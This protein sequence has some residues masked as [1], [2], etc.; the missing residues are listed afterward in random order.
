MIR[1]FDITSLERSCRDYILS[2][3]FRREE[4]ILTIIDSFS[5]FKMPNRCKKAKT[6]EV[7]TPLWIFMI[8]KN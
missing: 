5:M 8:T 2:D 4:Y 1:P 7:V 6:S 3:F